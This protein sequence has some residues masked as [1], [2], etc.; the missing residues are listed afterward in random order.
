MTD[1]FEAWLEE[2]LARDF[3]RSAAHPGPTHPRYR[4]LAG[5][6]G[7]RGMRGLVSAIVGTKLGLALTA[8]TVVAATGASVRATEVGSI[9]PLNWGQQVQ[10]QVV[11]CQHD[12][13]AANRGIG[14]CVS[15]DARQNGDRQS[16]SHSNGGG[17]PGSHGN[18]TTGKDTAPGQTGEHPTPAAAAHPTPPA[19]AAV[20][21]PRPHGGGGAHADDVPTPR[22]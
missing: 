20:P 1:R 15:P 11:Q 21:T 22:S 4:Q 16:D 13:T 17:S 7:R 10:Q 14:A 8:A 2:A 19:G 12:R 6:G 18:G 9:D 3:A 5:A